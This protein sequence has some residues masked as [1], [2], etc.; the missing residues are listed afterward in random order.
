M[1]Q[2]MLYL[3]CASFGVHQ[4]VVSDTTIHSVQR[5]ARIIVVLRNRSSLTECTALSR[6]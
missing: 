2:Y 5:N 3:L 6:I 1:N 4:A